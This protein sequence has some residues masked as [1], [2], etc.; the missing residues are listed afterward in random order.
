M[1]GGIAFVQVTKKEAKGEGPHAN[2]N[3][4]TQKP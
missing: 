3:T 4:L 2:P 1:R